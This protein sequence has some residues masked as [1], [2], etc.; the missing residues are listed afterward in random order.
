LEVLV[1]DNGS[2]DRSPEIARGYPVQ[3]LRYPQ[4]KVGAVRNFG[5]AHSEGE[6]LVF[7]DADCTADIDW[8]NRGLESLG[9]KWDAVG[10]L[11]LLRE[12]PSWMER[13]WIL[14]SGLE[15][16]YQTTLVGG[17]ILIWRRVFE[18]IGGFDEGLSAGEDS[19]LTLRLRRAGYA[20]AIDPRLSV[21]HLGF[22]QTV[23]S[24]VRRQIWHSESDYQNLPR[25]LKD[26]MFLL[27]HVFMLG[28]LLVLASPLF[29]AAA[30]W[31]GAMAVLGTPALLSAKRILRHRAFGLGAFGY[32]SV[33]IID[34]FYLVGR[35]L[36]AERS[37]RMMLLGD[38]WKKTT[39]R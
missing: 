35:L 15:C 11:Y 24:F 13:Y 19:D 10:G 33:Y 34:G 27:T 25:V 4:A 16:V 12:N 21:V 37:L 20:V 29:G 6:L 2:T 14:R 17:C 32:L 36:G 22:P 31:I 3:V 7:V 1:V 23:Q 8:L 28:L 9:E 18:A 30:G 38:S 39:R 5:A 26:R